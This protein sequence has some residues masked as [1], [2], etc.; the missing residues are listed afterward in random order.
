[1]TIKNRI[2]PV[3]LHW[4]SDITR[5]PFRRLPPLCLLCLLGF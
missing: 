1:M 3:I 4:F 2:L 5:P